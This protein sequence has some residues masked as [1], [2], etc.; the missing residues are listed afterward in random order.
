MRKFGIILL[1][2]PLVAC[3][4]VPVERK[5]PAA[6]ESIVQQ[7]PELEA[8]PV[9]TTKLSDILIV[10]TNNYALYH[11]CQLKVET[12]NEWYNTQKKIYEK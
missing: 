8:V 1:L 2:L 10:V 11:D 12:W 5:F 4:S 3:I 7:C 9:G 6:P